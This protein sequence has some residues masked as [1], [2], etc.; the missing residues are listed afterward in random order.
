MDTDMSDVY[1]Y[2]IGAGRVIRT[3]FDSLGGAIHTI[4][5]L[6]ATITDNGLY[7]ARGYEVLFY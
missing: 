6:D 7:Y 5:L 4:D 2:G 3:R 1:I